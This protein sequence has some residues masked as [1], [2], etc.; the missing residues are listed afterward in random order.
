MPLIKRT[1]PV[2]LRGIEPAVHPDYKLEKALEK[3]SK[4]DLQSMGMSSSLAFRYH[5]FEIVSRHDAEAKAYQQLKNSMAD[6]DSSIVHDTV[7]E[8]RYMMHVGSRLIDVVIVEY[9]EGVDESSRSHDE[10]SSKKE[11]TK[12]PS[13]S[14]G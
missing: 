10:S 14:D 9:Y 1:L 6:P 2:E 5:R 3:Q 13:S 11:R 8:H 4:A 7:I 12:R